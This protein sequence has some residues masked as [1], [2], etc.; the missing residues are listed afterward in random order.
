M[1]ETRSFRELVQ[2]RVVRDPEFATAILR[3]GVDAMLSGDVDA[4]KSI[5]RYYIEAG[6]EK[7]D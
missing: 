2:S 4:G 5:L 6:S 1:G 3:E 7:L